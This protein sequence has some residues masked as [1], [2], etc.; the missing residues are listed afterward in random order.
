MLYV[1]NTHTKATIQCPSWVDTSHDAVVYAGCVIAVSRGN[2]TIKK[3]NFFA[4]RPYFGVTDAVGNE[5]TFVVLSDYNTDDIAALDLAVDS[6][7]MVEV[8]G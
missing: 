5:Q 1:Q 8:V 7:D 6:V 4:T 2:I 3:D